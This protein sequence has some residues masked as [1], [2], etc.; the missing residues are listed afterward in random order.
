MIASLLLLATA[1]NVTQKY[2][3]PLKPAGSGMLQCTTP[4]TVHKTCKSIAAY[5]L[6]PDGGYKNTGIVMLSPRGPVTMRIVSL[7]TIIDNADCGT[8][9]TED[10]KAANIFVAGKKVSAKQAAP[11]L[12]KVEIAMAS[13]I[14]HQIC[15]RIEE[16][17]SGSVTKGFVDGVYHPEADEPMIWV[18]PEDGYRVA[19]PT[20]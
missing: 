14:G 16:T 13:L 10:I 2:A 20:I 18:K 11:I 4:D 9:R 3:D 15:E 5:K 8:L 6:M 7:L 12:A 1:G 19:P 17:E